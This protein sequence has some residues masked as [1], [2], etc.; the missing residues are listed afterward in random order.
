MKL[1]W[2]QNRK[3]K[4][5]KYARE[6]NARSLVIGRIEIYL[7]R[8]SSDADKS[9]FLNNFK[10]GAHNHTKGFEFWDKHRDRNVEPILIGDY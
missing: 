2:T 8:N 1:K 9:I 4:F 10:T 3:I 7:P 5:L 6:H